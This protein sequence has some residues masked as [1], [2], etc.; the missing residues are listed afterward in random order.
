M[1]DLSIKYESIRSKNYLFTHFPR[2]TWSFSIDLFIK[3]NCS[4]DTIWR[5]FFFFIKKRESHTNTQIEKGKMLFN[6]V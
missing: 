5:A 6:R 2:V 1:V 4:H 3:K